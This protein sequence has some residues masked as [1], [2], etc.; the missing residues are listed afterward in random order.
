MSIGV[1]SD[2]DDTEK[3][4]DLDDVETLMHRADI[5]MYQA[6]KQGKNRYF[7]F[8][9]SMEKRT[10]VPQRIGNRHPARCGC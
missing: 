2:I 6:K 7:W 4:N 8:E 10:A 9:P 5:A 1:T 3:S